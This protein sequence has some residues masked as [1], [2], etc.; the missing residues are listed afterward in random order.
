MAAA[1]GGASYALRG[2]SGGGERP[3][4][5]DRETLIMFMMATMVAVVGLVGFLVAFCKG[6]KRNGF[7]MND[8]SESFVGDK[9]LKCISGIREFLC[10]NISFI[11]R[12][13]EIICPLI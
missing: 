6:S 4:E 11:Y 13:L 2:L 1:A 10:L 12:L 5:E 8:P 7:K 3:R 9:S